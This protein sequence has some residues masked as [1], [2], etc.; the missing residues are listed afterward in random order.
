MAKGTTAA[1][2][3]AAQ[4]VITLS[5]KEI[6]AKTFAFCKLDGE[7][8]C[9]I[10]GRYTSNKGWE[11]IRFVTSNGVQFIL[12][13]ANVLNA[14]GNSPVMSPFCKI[15]GDNA[16]FLIGA[17]AKMTFKAPAEGQLSSTLMSIG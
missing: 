3:E 8:L 4:E 9:A 1:K 17:S 5:V 13:A 14:G 7:H 6:T 10:I 15:D 16:Q 12:G 2:K 11:G